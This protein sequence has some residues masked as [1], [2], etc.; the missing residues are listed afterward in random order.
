[1]IRNI[2]ALLYLLAL[3]ACG[4]DTGNPGLSSARTL[5]EADSIE[6]NVC[7]ILAYCH[8]VLPKDCAGKLQ[9]AKP[10]TYYL[11]IDSQM[12]PDLLSV[13]SAVGIKELFYNPVERQT[14][15]EE[16]QQL[17]CSS[18]LVQSAFDI[19]AS[20]DY[21]KLYRLLYV[22]PSCGKMLTHN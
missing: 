12:Y 21:S 2:L 18:D 1:M 16:M 9:K 17:S 11:G 13:N 8:K 15:F 5:S 10:F 14:C 22:N 6:A 19:K 7:N 3:S 20:D 4:T